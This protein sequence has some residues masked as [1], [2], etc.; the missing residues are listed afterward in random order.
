MNV[1]DLRYGGWYKITGFFVFM[2]FFKKVLAIAAIAAIAA[3]AAIAAIAARVARTT[4]P[5]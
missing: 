1:L 3:R 4:I 2:G 5:T